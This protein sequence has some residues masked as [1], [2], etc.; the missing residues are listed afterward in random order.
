MYIHKHVYVEMMI[1]KQGTGTEAFQ[2][3]ILVYLQMKIFLQ[4]FKS[5]E[6]TSP[7]LEKIFHPHP[8]H[9]KRWGRRKVELCLLILHG[10]STEFTL[11]HCRGLLFFH[12]FHKSFQ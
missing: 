4:R 10:G 6:R 9:T 3:F 12:I 7:F 5:K 11:A 2:Y 8:P 1:I